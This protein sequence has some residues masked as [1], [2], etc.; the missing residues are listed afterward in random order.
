MQRMIFT[1]YSVSEQAQAEQ[2]GRWKWLNIVNG[3]PLFT[4]TAQE[5]IPQALNLQ[6]LEQAISFT[7]GCYIGQKPL[8]V[9]SIV[10]QIS[11]LAMFTLVAD[12]IEAVEI[13]SSVQIALENGWRKTGTS[14]ISPIISSKRGYK[15]C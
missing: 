8:R 2:A 7:K 14:L 9:L 12:E 1:C 3:E 4:A 13:G 10:V 15:W 5:F 6:H 11:C